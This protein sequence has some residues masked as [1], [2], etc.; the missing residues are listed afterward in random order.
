M[1]L[2]P[3]GECQLAPG[4]KL[5]NKE[6]NHVKDYVVHNWITGKLLSSVRI[7]KEKALPQ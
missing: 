4:A 5:R 3:C 1:I 7:P 6:I 2:F